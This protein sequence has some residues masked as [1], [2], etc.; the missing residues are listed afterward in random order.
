M[1]T[2]L[3]EVRAFLRDVPDTETLTAVQEAATSRLLELDAARRPVITPGRTGKIN[4]DIRPAALRN[5]TGT[6]QQP[7][8]TKT[9]FDFLLT[10]EATTRLRHLQ[11][12]YD[13][14]FKIPEGVKRYRLNK[15]P[16]TCIE[17]DE[18]TD[19]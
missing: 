10:E 13:P 17:L 3:D 19:S 12:P 14:R 1:T 18:P 8:R 16:A 2:T 6:V 4:S 9:R 5:L 7:N 15:E 11:D